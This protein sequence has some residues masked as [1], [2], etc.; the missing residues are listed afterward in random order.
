[1]YKSPGMPLH[2]PGLSHKEATKGLWGYPNHSGGVDKWYHS[3]TT[4][5][6]NK[7]V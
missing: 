1:M 7:T 3:L 2:I 5:G 6:I 4:I